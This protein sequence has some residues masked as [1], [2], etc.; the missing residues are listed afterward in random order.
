MVHTVV[1]AGK[2]Q[3]L[4]LTSWRPMR[5]NGAVSVRRWRLETQEM[6]M[7]PSEFNSRKKASVLVQNLSGRKNFVIQG[8]VSLFVLFRPSADWMKPTHIGE[9]NLL[10]SV[11]QF[12]C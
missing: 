9:G 1:K 5:A 4:H 11:C 6:L 10:Y 2:S 8:K 12:R 3:D 7:F